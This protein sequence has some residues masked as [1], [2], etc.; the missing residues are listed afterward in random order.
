MPFQLSH[1]PLREYLEVQLHV[2]IVPERELE[3]AL[4]RWGQVAALCRTH[5]QTRVLVV[6][7]FTGT[8]D[9]EIKF[10]LAKGAS[11]IGWSYELKLAVVISDIHHFNEQL[12][13]ETAMNALGYEMKLFPKYR[14]A[15]K[16]LLA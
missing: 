12:F 10:R 1:T 6:M 4:E 7:E 11:D 16:W 15:R 13:T 5:Q 8:H 2:Q 3:E 14:K 9:T